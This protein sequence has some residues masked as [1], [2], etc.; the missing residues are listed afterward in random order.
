[1]AFD[2]AAARGGG[3][4]GAGG[5]G[6][7]GGGGD[8]VIA[9]LMAKLRMLGATLDAQERLV[10]GVGG[11]T[12]GAALRA[13]LAAAEGKASS[14]WAD[15]DGGSRALRVASLSGRA[16]AKGGPYE[17]FEAAKSAM[18]GRLQAALSASRARQAE[19]PPPPPPDDG[20]AGGGGGV[21]TNNVLRDA[22]AL[23]MIRPLDSVDDAIM[24]VRSG[25]PRDAAH[26]RAA[27]RAQ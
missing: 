1:M 6:G 10:G 26:A 3:G 16:L 5:D 22:V 4:G 15:V 19:A 24:E 12:D 21:R 13:R 7:G 11:P 20:G 2:A 25:A 27:Q 14:L 8:G 18:R 23:S 17:Q 9:S